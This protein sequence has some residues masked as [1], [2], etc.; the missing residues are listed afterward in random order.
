MVHCELALLEH[1]KR[2]KGITPPFNYIAVS[3]LSCEP[4]IQAFNNSLHTTYCTAGGH[5]KYYYPW[6]APSLGS[7]GFL[8]DLADS[9]SRSTCERWAAMVKRKLRSYS[10]S[11]LGSLIDRGAESLALHILKIWLITFPIKLAYPVSP[12]WSRKTGR[13]IQDIRVDFRA[14]TGEAFYH[15]PSTY[16]MEGGLNGPLSTFRNRRVAWGRFAEY[17]VICPKMVEFLQAG[18]SG[19]GV[20][21][22]D[23]K[24]GIIGIGYGQAYA[25]EGGPTVALVYSMKTIL[26]RVYYMTGLQ[27]RVL[28]A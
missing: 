18:D 16:C 5:E 2:Q 26:E 25:L 14:T 3:K 7:T 19:S 22:A 28:R 13:W 12:S 27:L 6:G 20:I 15:F 4:Y 21:D 24:W 17:A 1:Y 10:D 8:N 11:S 9:M 23:S